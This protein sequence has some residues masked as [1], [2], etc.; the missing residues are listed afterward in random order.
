MKIFKFSGEW[1]YSKLMGSTIFWGVIIFFAL[2]F[3]LFFGYKAWRKSKSSAMSRRPHNRNSVDQ[4][5]EVR[6]SQQENPADAPTQI[7]HSLPGNSA[8]AQ[9]VSKPSQKS[10]LEDA[11]T[12]IRPDQKVIPADEQQQFKNPRK[13]NSADAPTQVGREPINKVD[14]EDDRTTF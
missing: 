14:P 5:R 4:R 3:V 10:Y 1:R 12:K 6:H 7:G 8:D 9:T 13:V 2:I 11:Q